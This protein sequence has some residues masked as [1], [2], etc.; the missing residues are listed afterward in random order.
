VA[1]QVAPIVLRLRSEASLGEADRD[2]HR[3]AWQVNRGAPVRLLAG[4]A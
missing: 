3:D 2:D 4:E 1:E